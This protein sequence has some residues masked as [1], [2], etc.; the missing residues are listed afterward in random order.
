MRI[1]TFGNLV[2]LAAAL[3]AV[4]STSLSGADAGLSLTY[5]LQVSISFQHI[6]NVFGFKNGLPLFEI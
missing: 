4:L 1:Q 5:A 2:V 3:F 6:Y